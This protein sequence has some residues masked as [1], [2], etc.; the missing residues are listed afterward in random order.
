M[1]RYIKIYSITAALILFFFSCEEDYQQVTLTFYPTLEG[2]SVEPAI[3]AAG[4]PSVVKLRTSRVLAEDSKVNI[5]IAGNGAGYGNSYTTSPPQLQPGIITLT[6]PRGEVET[7]FTFTPKND[8][9]FIPTDY[10]YTFSIEATNADIKSVGQG[11]FKMTVTDNTAGF[12]DEKFAACPSALFSER[13]VDG[14]NTWACSGFGSPDEAQA[15]SC[16]EA[17]SFN[18]G[19]ATGCNTYLV[20]NEVIDG[21]AYENLYISTDVYSRF[22]GSGGIEFVYSTDY[23]GSGNPEADGVT[24][25]PIEKLNAGIPAAGTQKWTNTTALIEAPDGPI[26]IAVHHSGGTTASS[27]SWRIDNFSI[28]GN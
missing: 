27:S 14:P 22:T 19:N 11:N 5:R 18:K 4:S 13:V 1:N 3:D 24:W 2:V 23:S 26:Y 8:N 9:V 21:S 6:I 25:A 7:Q 15:N 16:M 28:K 20:I 17:N 12:I 10:Q